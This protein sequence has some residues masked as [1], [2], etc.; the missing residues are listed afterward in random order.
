MATRSGAFTINEWLMKVRKQR[1]PTPTQKNSFGALSCGTSSGG[2]CKSYRPA[3]EWSSYY[4][5]EGLSA[6]E[7][8]DVLE[9]TPVAIK[10]RL[11]SARIKLRERRVP[12]LLQ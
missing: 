6:D 11:W 5:I 12:L 4:V 3:Y 9:L 8:A 1:H 10:A 2:N 7:T